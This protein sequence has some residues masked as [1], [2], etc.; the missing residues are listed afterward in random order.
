M[1]RLDSLHVCCWDVTE[2]MLVTFFQSR[3]LPNGGRD[4]LFVVML[5]REKWKYAVSSVPFILPL[6]IAPS[7]SCNNLYNS[8]QK[9]LL[10]MYVQKMKE[11]KTTLCNNLYSSKKIRQTKCEDAIYFST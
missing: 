4:V 6:A 5:L 8:H 11:N 2:L 3:C 10:L 7:Y 9:N 1:P